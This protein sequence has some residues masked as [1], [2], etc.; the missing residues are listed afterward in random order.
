MPKSIEFCLSDFL[1]P[2]ALRSLSTLVN[3]FRNAEDSEHKDSAFINETFLATIS[4]E[5]Q[6]FVEKHLGKYSEN[7]FMM[8]IPA[9]CFRNYDINGPLKL[10]FNCSLKL[11][12]REMWGN[13]DLTQEGRFP[14]VFE[15]LS[16]ITKQLYSL[17]FLE[18]PRCYFENVDEDQVE[19]LRNT[20]VLLGGTVESAK[21]DATF[22][23]SKDSFA[24]S[25]D[26]EFV[27]VIDYLPNDNEGLALIHWWYYPDSYDKWV[28][29]NDVE[30]MDP[31]ELS[32]YPIQKVWSISSKFF[33]DSKD[34]NEW[35]NPEDYE[36]EEDSNEIEGSKIINNEVAQSSSSPKKSKLHKKKYHE[37]QSKQRENIPILESTQS[38]EKYFTDIAP[39][40]L[41]KDLEISVFDSNSGN[42]IKLNNDP[43]PDSREIKAVTLD[44]DINIPKWFKSDTISL[45][46][47]RYLPDAVSNASEYLRVRNLIVNL[48]NKNPIMYLSAT[49]CRQ[50][51][52][53]DVGLIFRIHEFLDAFGII[54]SFVKADSRPSPITLTYINSNKR[55]R[56][57]TN[58]ND[59]FSSNFDLAL[60]K[61]VSSFG[62]NWDKIAAE[63]NSLNFD[64]NADDCLM[65]F[66][67]LSISRDHKDSKVKVVRYSL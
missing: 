30:N 38:T 33:Y 34:F 1:Q 57:D 58:E 63:M 56:I 62:N 60:L 50:K 5:I 11:L 25:T 15:L 53:G 3:Y 67:S 10:I 49:D 14:S 46:E 61:Y 12:K 26:E 8:K 17:K 52:S 48:C 47:L 7:R 65:R 51:F 39:P 40:S 18:Y 28:N 36:I 54:N 21:E 42:L 31:S 37:N 59:K 2:L 4:F 29:S 64:C 24:D 43:K 6:V 16:D 41:Q 19:E 35:C 23:I 27:R 20:I 32:L 66:V 9:I 44:N 22:L 45:I 55:K 13:F